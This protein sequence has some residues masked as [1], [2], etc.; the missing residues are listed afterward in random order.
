MI[1]AGRLGNVAMRSSAACRVALGSG[2]AS[3][4]EADMAVADLN[5]GEPVHRCGERFPDA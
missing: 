2:L 4:V 3:L 5:E 1:I